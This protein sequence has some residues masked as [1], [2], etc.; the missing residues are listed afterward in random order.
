MNLQAVTTIDLKQQ[1]GQL[2]AVPVRLENAERAM[3]LIYAADFETDPYRTLPVDLNGDG[4]HELVYQHDGITI[5]RHGQPQG[6]VNGEV[7]QVSKFLDHPGEHIVSFRRDGF[8]QFWLDANAQDSPQA[9]QRFQQATY[10]TNQSLSAV[11]Y[12]LT[13]LTGL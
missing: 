12:N 2:R 8:V 6:S 7:A 1:I 5:D 4:Y 13:L 9:Q 3:L 10:Q 11:G